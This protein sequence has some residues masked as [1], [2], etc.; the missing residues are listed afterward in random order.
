MLQ[1]RYLQYS[2][3]IT[4]EVFSKIFYI[5][6]QYG[7]KPL[8][9]KNVLWEDFKGEKHFLTYGPN[10]L[11]YKS[12]C[13]YTK[14][15][16]LDSDTPITVEEI[17]DTYEKELLEP[18]E[19]F[20]REIRVDS[21]KDLELIK[22][23]LLFLCPENPDKLSFDGNIG[24]YY[25]LYVKNHTT[26]SISFKYKDYEEDGKSPSSIYHAISSYVR[27][28]YEL[29]EEFFES[30]EENIKKL[31]KEVIENSFLKNRV[32]LTE[33]PPI[34]QDLLVEP[35][36]E[37]ECFKDVTTPYKESNIENEISL[38]KEGAIIFYGIDKNKFFPEISEIL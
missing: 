32:M 4:E 35:L 1:G 15:C 26:L 2:E 34:T 22:K 8:F 14:S 24:V 29:P 3:D 7:Y 30:F 17:F 5:I 19:S 21:E 9:E 20:K 31:L 12:F 37:K 11:G 6:S 18:F 33:R 36:L 28:G 10:N 38:P 16:I 27:A 13:V 23:F 25:F